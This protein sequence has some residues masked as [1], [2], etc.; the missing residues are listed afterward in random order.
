MS[1]VV[2][3][4]EF[5]TAFVVEAEELLT[6]A[7]TSLLDIEKALRAGNKNIRAVRELFRAVHTIKG[8]SSMV[9]IEP[10]VGIAHRLETTLRAADRAGGSLALES[11]DTLLEGVRAIAKRVR[12]LADGQPVAEAPSELLDRLERLE[13]ATPSTARQSGAG[14]LILDAEIAGKL[15]AQD[16]AQLLE[17]LAQGRRAL[18]VDFIPSPLRAEAG[19]T[20]TSVRARVA[21]IGDIVKVVPISVPVTADAP[22][23]LKFGLL[24]VTSE[25][26]Q[27]LADAVGVDPGMVYSLAAPPAAGILGAVLEAE[28]EEPSVSRHGVVRVDVERLDD[29]ME[30]LSTLVVTRFRLS[31]ALAELAA[32][33]ADVRAL[34]QIMNENGRQLRDLRAAILRVRMVPVSE[35]FERVPLLVRG[36]SRA[37]GKQVRLVIDA[38]TAEVDKGVAERLFPAVVHLVRNA[39]DHAFESPDERT[40]AGK[41]AEGAL[42]IACFERTNSQLE[43][44]ISDDGRGIDRK[45]VADRAHRPLP[46][47][48]AALL[49]LL[50][51]PGLSTRDEATMTSGRGMGMDIVKR[52]VEQLG[53]ELTL[54]TRVGVGTRFVMHVPVSISIVDAFTFECAAQRFVVPVTMVEEVVDIDPARL[55]RGPTRRGGEAPRLLERRNE[56]VPVVQLESLFRLGDRGGEARKALVVRRNGEPMAFSVDRMLGQQ[57]VVVRPLED[58]LVRVIGISGATDLGDGRPTLVLDLAALSGALSAATLEPAA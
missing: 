21:K 18:R 14:A 7:N 20:I 32:A 11:I 54:Q 41:P 29:V 38:G 56:T 30:R 16:Q 17:G 58:P 25:S 53:G 9:G 13:S 23:G 55:V 49:E 39:V 36:L 57:E 35:V 40:R 42:T 1:D 33:G 3:L 48:D 4:A 8:L 44:T 10:V 37:T 50:C 19:S 45:L 51:L 34:A 46:D 15:G 24:V 6:T 31:R 2:D 27:A 5:R 47:S 22:G 52:T 43:L 26:A 12:A 28:P